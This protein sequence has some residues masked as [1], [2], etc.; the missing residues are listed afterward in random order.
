MMTRQYAAGRKLPPIIKVGDNV[1]DGMHR[2]AAA[3]RAGRASIPA[4]YAIT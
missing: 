3:S 4:W 1:V 2:Q